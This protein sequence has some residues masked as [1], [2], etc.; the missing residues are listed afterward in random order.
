MFDF[1]KYLLLFM[2]NLSLSISS[3]NEFEK[4]GIYTLNE[5]FI[6]LEKYS[7]IRLEIVEPAIELADQQGFDG[8]IYDIKARIV[9]DKETIN[10]VFCSES[11]SEE[12]LK[13][14]LVSD[15]KAHKFSLNISTSKIIDYQEKDQKDLLLPEHATS[16][17][18]QSS[19]AKQ[20]IP[21][22]PLKF[23]DISSNFTLNDNTTID[24]DKWL[25]I[26]NT[27]SQLVKYKLYYHNG[28]E[29]IGYGVLDKDSLFIILSHDI[30]LFK[31]IIKG[32][33]YFNQ[34]NYILQNF[35]T[36]VV[37]G[38]PHEVKKITLLNYDIVSSLLKSY[39]QLSKIFLFYSEKIKDILNNTGKKN[40]ADRFFF[41]FGDINNHFVGIKSFRGLNSLSLL[42]KDS[43]GGSSFILDTDVN[44]KLIKTGMI[45]L[46]CEIS[47]YIKN[48]SFFGEVTHIKIF[49]GILSIKVNYL[50]TTMVNNYKTN[51]NAEVVLDSGSGSGLISSQVDRDNPPKAKR[52]KLDE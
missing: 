19:E 31:N 13:I 30:S 36:F 34:Q 1:Y 51:Y 18:S 4:S 46:I 50:T 11:Q 38:S 23:S 15:D 32:E 25:P 37:G 5:A 12:G 24:L 8:Y 44:N 28:Q 2:V 17:G 43:K 47:I 10:Y 48:C 49:N 26:K 21:T 40:I 33:L 14:L 29:K 9:L 3:C 42:L 27:I 35:K 20:S 45:V 52:P 7:N 16:I 6:A 39:M 41:V 22:K